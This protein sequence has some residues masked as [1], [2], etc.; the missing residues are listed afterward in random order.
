M[1]GRRRAARGS[2]HGPPPRGGQQFSIG[3]GR[4]GQADVLPKYSATRPSVRPTAPAWIQTTSPLVQSSSSQVGLGA[5]PPGQHVV[6][7][8]RLGQGPRPG[9]GPGSPQP[10]GTGP[11]SGV[12]ADW[13]V[14]IDA[15]REA[16]SG[17]RR[18]RLPVRPPASGERA[19]PPDPAQHLGV[20][21]FTL[22]PPDGTRPER[23]GAAGSSS[24]RRGVGS[25]RTVPA[26]RRWGTDR[27]YG[28]SVKAGF[29]SDPRRSSRNPAG[30]PRGTD[31]SASR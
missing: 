15:R 18:H 21:P 30:S 23:R 19:G 4:S 14:P 20:A 22:G 3:R 17:R 12:P 5:E 26:A 2:R 25:T 6:L 8:D 11:G 29:P 27:E 31:A 13:P 1:P 9:A 28:R 16:G 24:L 10:V 7:P